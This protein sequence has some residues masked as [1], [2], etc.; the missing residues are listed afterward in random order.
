MESV[1]VYSDGSSETGRDYFMR[2]GAA[3]ILFTSTGKKI[4]L[5]QKSLNKASSH[6][7]EYYGLLLGLK[8]AIELGATS[9]VLRSDCLVAL[10][11]IAGEFKINV[12]AIIALQQQMLPLLKQLTSY[13]LEHIPRRKNMLADK[14]AKAAVLKP[15]KAKTKNCFLKP[16]ARKKH[17]IKRGVKP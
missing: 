4:T 6:E 17:F 2:A 14:A 5:V 9:V 16:D 15:K 10:R 7:A 8:K 11:Q 1:I 3:A 13:R 12:P